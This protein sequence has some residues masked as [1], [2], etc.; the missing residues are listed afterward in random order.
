[1]LLETQVSTSF[2]QSIPESED[3]QCNGD[4][5]LPYYSPRDTF[6]TCFHAKWSLDVVL[7]G[8]MNREGNTELICQFPLRSSENSNQRLKST[9]ANSFGLCPSDIRVTPEFKVYNSTA[10]LWDREGKERCSIST[11]EMDGFEPRVVCWSISDKLLR[12]TFTTLSLAACC[13]TGLWLILEICECS[14]GA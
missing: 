13:H 2:R 8:Q 5:F 11:P 10:A 14:I 3:N 4:K 1:M 7:V 12:P 6:N 9:F